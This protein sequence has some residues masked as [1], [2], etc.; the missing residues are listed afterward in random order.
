MPVHKTRD[1]NP[2][3]YIREDSFA[4]S[5]L[6]PSSAT[7]LIAL[8]EIYWFYLLKHLVFG[9]YKTSPYTRAHYLKEINRYL[10][11]HQFQYK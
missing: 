8:I 2:M 3:A 7:I 6:M 10:N 9:L 4:Q 1:T 11:L 5:R